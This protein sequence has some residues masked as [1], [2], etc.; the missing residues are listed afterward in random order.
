MVGRKTN[1]CEWLRDCKLKKVGA[2]TNTYV[3]LI[4]MDVFTIKLPNRIKYNFRQFGPKIQLQTRASKIALPKIIA[5]FL[6]SYNQIKKNRSCLS[7]DG[8]LTRLC[9][10]FYVCIFCGKSRCEDWPKM[11]KCLRWGQGRGVTLFG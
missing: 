5:N 3:K 9:C 11:L 10:C 7:A 6:K 1:N 4:G 8:P 2:I